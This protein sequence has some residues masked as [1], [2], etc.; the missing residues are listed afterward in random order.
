MGK[1]SDITIADTKTPKPRKSEKQMV[2]EY[3]DNIIPP[4]LEFRDR[5]TS[6]PT[7]RTK[8]EKISKA[9]KGCTK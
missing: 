1:Q 3:E 4:P 6:V 5:Y 2:Q 9:L 7:P 8:I